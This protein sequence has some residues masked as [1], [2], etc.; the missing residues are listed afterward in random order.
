M[1]SG[2]GGVGGG[3]N[4]AGSPSFP[5]PFACLGHL[6]CLALPA[7]LPPHLPCSYTFAFAT[8]PAREHLPPYT[9]QEHFAWF[10][11]PALALPAPCPP[12]SLFRF[13]FQSG[14][15]YPTCHP[16]A[17]FCIPFH[18]NSLPPN[19]VPRTYL[20]LPPPPACLPCLAAAPLPATCL[21]CPFTCLP[22][23]TFANITCGDGVWMAACHLARGPGLGGRGLGSRILGPCHPHLPACLLALPCCPYLTCPYL[24]GIY[25]GKCHR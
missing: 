10:P 2:G 25:L 6:P 17:D 23:Q 20:P 13:R 5:P 21:P 22:R 3:Q 19:S 8:T 24:Y 1:V 14:R 15:I 12:C 11:L 16:L 18:L 9:L 4:W 7:A